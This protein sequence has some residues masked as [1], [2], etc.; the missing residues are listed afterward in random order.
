M[1]INVSKVPADNIPY[2]MILVGTGMFFGNILG[3]KLSDSISPTKAAIIC[4]CRLW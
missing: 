4:V 3:G 2:I 1:S